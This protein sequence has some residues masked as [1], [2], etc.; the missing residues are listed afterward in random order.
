M[1][2]T[3]RSSE[4][5]SAVVSSIPSTPASS[6]SRL[7]RGSRN[8]PSRSYRPATGAPRPAA[9]WKYT[10]ATS[11]VRP[12][13]SSRPIRCSTTT[14]FH[15]IGLVVAVITGNPTLSA[16]APDWRDVHNR[17]AHAGLCDPVPFSG[18][19]S[20]LVRGRPIW[21]GGKDRSEASM[22]EFFEW[23]GPR[24]SKGI[25]M[26]VMD[27]EAVS[28]LDQGPCSRGQHPLRQVPCATPPG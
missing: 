12:I 25:R 28:N 18:D 17:C 19:V 11:P 24:K 21:F 4:D 2:V 20:D 7:A 22:D 1:A 8:R 6:D 16:G 14:G 23:L 10:I 26:A 13:R 9:G 5:P 15:G 3:V 27:L